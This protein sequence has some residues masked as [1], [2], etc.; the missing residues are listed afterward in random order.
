M[1]FIKD[2]ATGKIECSIPL[3]PSGMKKRMAKPNRQALHVPAF[4]EETI[5]QS[6]LLVQKLNE[7]AAKTQKEEPSLLLADLDT[8]TK[9]FDEPCFEFNPEAFEDDIFYEDF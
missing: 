1:V 6:E 7:E 8:P 9:T 3:Q 5:L 4:A 2:T